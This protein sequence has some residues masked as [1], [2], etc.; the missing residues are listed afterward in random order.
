MT[1]LAALA[2]L[3]LALGAC[4]ARDQ[5]RD[6][7]ARLAHAP[8][9]PSRH[10]ALEANLDRM[11]DAGA[12]GG[13]SPRRATPIVA[14]PRWI[15][16]PVALEEREEG[17]AF[18]Q[19][20]SLD[21]G[22]AGALRGNRVSVALV[23]G[24]AGPDVPPRP[25][26]AGI[27]EE[28]AAQFPD[29]AMQVVPRA[30]ANAYGP[31]GLA[32]GRSAGGARCLYA[33]QWIE[34]PPALE[35]GTP[36]SGPLSLRV[37]LCRADISLEAMA[38]AVTQLRLVPRFEGEAPVASRPVARSARSA[39]PRAHD[40]ASVARRAEPAAATAATIPANPAPR[41]AGGRLYLGAEPSAAPPAVPAVAWSRPS[42][43]AAAAAMP[44]EPAVSA[45]PLP[46]EAF[47]GP[48]GGR[49]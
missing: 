30:S 23:G 7:M 2:A 44:A 18:G 46:P 19:I 22:P 25:T 49:S 26:E 29:M 15:G 43:A 40:R 14:M 3:C 48:A 16:R 28:L 41:E 27:R 32:I 36:R 1:R 37:R 21:L 38:A 33:W 45:D 9:V 39:R 31:Y 13:A 42:P 10:V 35:P 24:D 11:L 6:P 8:S 47:R 5:A 12:V 34:T 4:Q 17:G 20:V